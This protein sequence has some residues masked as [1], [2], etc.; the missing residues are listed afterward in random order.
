[1]TRAFRKKLLATTVAA[2]VFAPSVALAQDQ[3][4]FAEAQYRQAVMKHFNISIQKI[5]QNFQGNVQHP[6][7]YAALANIMANAATMSK[8]AFEK[9]TRGMEGPTKAKAEIWDNWEDFSGRMDKMVE[10]TAAF[11]EAAKSGDMSQIQPGFRRAVSQCK[12]CH[13]LYK[14]D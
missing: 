6:D 5:L 14:A 1:M 7:H 2:A 9:D 13:D 8:A 3:Q 10:D 4:T 12:G 11:A